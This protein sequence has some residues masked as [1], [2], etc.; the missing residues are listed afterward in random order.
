MISLKS[1]LLRGSGEEYDAPYRRIIELLMQGIALHAVEGEQSDYE[2]FREELDKSQKT[3]TPETPLAELLVVAGGVLRTMEEYN[4][5]T[6]KFVRHQ[7]TELQNMISM[8]TQTVISIGSSSDRSVS[9]LQEIDKAIERANQVEDIH[10]LK[11]RLGECLEVVREETLRQKKDGES[12]LQ[13]L[14]GQLEAV[15][16]RI[17]SMR[18]KN[19]MDRSTG[20]PPK[21]EADAAIEAAMSATQTTYLLIAVCSRVQAINARFGYDVGD[22]VLRTFAEHIRKSLLPRDKIYRWNGPAIVALLP[23]NARIDRVRSEVRHFADAKVEKTIEV[24]QRTVL[25]PIS[26]TWALLPVVPPMEV[27]CKQIDA[28]TS[29]QIPRD[30]A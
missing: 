28:F 5:R 25:I 4:Q 10:V 16:E 7:N 29:A 17:G 22:R 23:R 20:L 21:T 6:S 12:A 2:R 18:L 15:Q 19:E 3:V 13:T 14:K 1:Y 24:G 8:L 9:K 26:A 11:H 30:F 27:L